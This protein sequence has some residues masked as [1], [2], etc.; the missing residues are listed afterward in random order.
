ML[1]GRL[2]I[3]IHW[4]G[5]LLKVIQWISLKQMVWPPWH[6]P[7]CFVLGKVIWQAGKNSM[8]SLSLKHL[9]KFAERL[10]NGKCTW[11]FASHPIFPYWALDMKQWHQLLSQANTYL[12]ELKDMVNRFSIMCLKY[13]AVTSTATNIGKSCWLWWRRKVARVTETV[14]E[15][16]KLF[17]V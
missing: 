1:L 6:F 10:P 13:R 12:Q 15:Q 17:Q 9:I 16:G 2:W 7:L 5:H 4:S 11:T 8:G 3:K 14:A